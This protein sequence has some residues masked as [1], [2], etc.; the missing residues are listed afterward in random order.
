[1]SEV[2]HTPTPWKVGAWKTYIDS[3]DGVPILACREDNGAVNT[4]FII[5]AVNCHVKLLEALKYLTTHA[6]E[7]HEGG[8]IIP[9]REY[10]EW[11]IKGRAAIAEA[12]GHS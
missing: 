5:K 10:V 2:K 12:E 9:N 3:D 11:M 1:M 8:S 4:A 6:T 7:R